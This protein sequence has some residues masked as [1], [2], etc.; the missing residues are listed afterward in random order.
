MPFAFSLLLQFVPF[1]SYPI[2]TD[3]CS[4]F[5]QMSLSSPGTESGVPASPSP[6]PLPCH[7]IPVR[8]PS[9]QISRVSH[10]FHADP[11][12]KFSLCSRL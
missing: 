2:C 9:S 5:C 4:V 7:P 8:A 10:I 12:G 11:H 1:P 6:L 3:M